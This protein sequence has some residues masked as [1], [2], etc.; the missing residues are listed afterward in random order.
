M[1]W[2]RRTLSLALVGLLGLA[3]FSLAFAPTDKDPLE[4]T[5]RRDVY[6]HVKDYPGLHLSQIARGV[7]LTTN[8]VKYHLRVLEKN[9]L[10]T[11]I[12]QDGYWRFFPKENGTPLTRE[13]V[14][15]G[16]KPV[17]SLLRKPVPLQITLHL[18]DQGE[19]NNKRIAEAVGV[20]PS[21]SHYHLGTMQEAGML[22]DRR[23][24]RSVVYELA[25]PERIR[26]LLH[27]H[28]PP[29]ELVEGFLEAWD[30]MEL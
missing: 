7:D 21:T 6:E 27:Q 13:T 10:V 14:D 4:Q 20:S 29:G 25:D 2:I 16:D 18:L 19:A 12:R 26:G 24:G 22:E 11:S 3:S 28:E 15:H 9:D 23:E 17:L 8:H 5:V 1:G 30:P